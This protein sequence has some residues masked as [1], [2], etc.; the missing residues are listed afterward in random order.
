MTSGPSHTQT[1]TDTD[2]PIHDQISS[3]SQP[4]HTQTQTVTN[5]T[6]NVS[7][8]T[9]S[10]SASKTPHTQAPAVYLPPTLGQMADALVQ[11]NRIGAVFGE[12]I[13]SATYERLL[14]GTQPW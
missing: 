1:S 9:S 14:M 6:P 4:P 10:S 2:G 5:A 3:L 12:T 13:D 8:I 11:A 7:T